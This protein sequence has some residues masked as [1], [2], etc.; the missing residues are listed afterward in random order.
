MNQDYLQESDEFYCWFESCYEKSQNKDDFIK[1]GGVYNNFTCSEYY[2]NLNK[3]EKR[4]NNKT[5]F[6]ERIQ[7]HIT[8]RKFYK[9][10]LQYKENGKYTTARNVLTGFSIK[11]DEDKNDEF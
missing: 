7:K 11:I 8:L 9:E 10:K 5:K 2:E 3:K 6:L 1:L 4:L